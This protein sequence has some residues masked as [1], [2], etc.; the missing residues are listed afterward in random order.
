MTSP[1]ILVSGLK[2]GKMKGF[3]PS[4]HQMAILD[5]FPTILLH[6]SEFNPYLLKLKNIYFS[7]VAIPVY[8]RHSIHLKGGTGSR[9]ELTVGPKQSMGKIVSFHWFLARKI[10]AV[11]GI[12]H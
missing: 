9:L 4:F 10:S 8:V 1:S 6:K 12:D 7:M 11:W 3:S 2:N 5:F